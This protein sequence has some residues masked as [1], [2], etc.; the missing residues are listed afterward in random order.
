MLRMTNF[1]L[2]ALSWFVAM[3]TGADGFGVVHDRD[4]RMLVTT[5]SSAD[6]SPRQVEDLSLVTIFSNLGT[7]YPK[8]VYFIKAASSQMG[9]Q[10]SFG[11]SQYWNAVAFT[12]N[13]SHNVTKIEVALG[14]SSGANK[15]VLSLNSDNG[16]VPGTAI[17]TWHPQ[18]LPNFGSCCATVVVRDDG[19]IP[20]SA[21]VQYW[22]VAS[23]NNQDSDFSGGWYYNTT[24]QVDVVQEAY[25]CSDDHGGTCGA[26]NDRWTLFPDAPALAFAVFGTP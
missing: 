21:G 6:F 15:I 23:T 2:V 9:P 25:Y 24:D 3:V 11:F 26:N 16:G 4:G 10:N 13:A 14:H 1:T 17:R 22:I 20:V 19:G 12:P 7:K 8:G 18:N 5:R